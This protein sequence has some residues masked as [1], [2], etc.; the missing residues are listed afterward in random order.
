MQIEHIPQH[1][2]IIMD[3][4]GRWAKLAGK[5]RTD[6]HVAG[7]QTTK[8]IVKAARDMGIKHLSLY[9]FSTEN[10]KR[11]E[12]EVSFLMGLI[13]KHLGQEYTF[14]RENHIRVVH[15][16]G[17]DQLPGYVQKEIRKVEADTAQFTDGLTVNLLINYGGKDEICRAVQKL[18]TNGDAITEESIRKYFDHPEIPDLDLVIRTAG[19]YRLS[20]FMIWQA[21]YAE[22]YAIDK[23][24]PDFNEDDFLQAIQQYNHRERKF[25]AV[26]S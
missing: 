9:A 26:L 10:W 7:L 22:Y 25:G 24:W 19:E 5:K 17:I 14:Y 21:S 23:L 18:C 13:A 8:K 2:G 12:E 16:G 11:A 20:N 15:S 6:G 4:N 3:G 1:V